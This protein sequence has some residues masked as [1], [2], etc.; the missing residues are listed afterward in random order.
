[1]KREFIESTIIQSHGKM[2]PTQIN[3]YLEEI[4]NQQVQLRSI[5][6]STQCEDKFWDNE[7]KVFINTRLHKF[8]YTLG[9]TQIAKYIDK[10]GIRCTEKAVLISLAYVEVDL[11]TI[12]I[13]QTFKGEDTHEEYVK[14]FLI[15]PYHYE[16]NGKCPMTKEEKQ[17]QQQEERDTRLSIYIALGGFFVISFLMIVLLCLLR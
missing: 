15:K 8:N 3:K 5:V 12:A 9:D 4:K 11:E 10:W 16:I 14:Q 1:M 17:R 7:K 2:T 6:F 13:Y